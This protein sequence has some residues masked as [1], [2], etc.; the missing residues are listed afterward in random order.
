MASRAIWA[1]FSGLGFDF[2]GGW[3][4]CFLSS[5]RILCSLCCRQSRKKHA[6]WC[7]I[8]RL[9]KGRLRCASPSESRATVATAPG[10]AHC[11]AVRVNSIHEIIVDVGRRLLLCC[12]E[13]LREAWQQRVLR[14][15]VGLLSFP[16]WLGVH[17]RD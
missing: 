4:W 6:L 17:R 10:L 16:V 9:G 12:H 15:G 14:T 7:A 1:T 8:S 11:A 3:A 13:H 2:M 5:A